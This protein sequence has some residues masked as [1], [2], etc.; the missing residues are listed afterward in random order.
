MY[1]WNVAISGVTAHLS[2][3]V[4]GSSH[5]SGMSMFWLG[6][7]QKRGWIE[8]HQGI[9]VFSL[10]ENKKNVPKKARW[11][12]WTLTSASQ[13]PHPGTCRGS[14]LQNYSGT[15]RVKGVPLEL[16]LSLV[17]QASVSAAEHC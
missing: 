17:T 5:G 6:R 14:S 15:T 13:G 12:C 7:A 9:F 16:L 11:K 3:V 1:F 10:D 4:I 8:S 2:E